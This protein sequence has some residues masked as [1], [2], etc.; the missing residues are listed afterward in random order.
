MSD[1]EAVVK[2][3]KGHQTDITVEGE[4]HHVFFPERESYDSSSWPGNC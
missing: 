3:D 1:M 2:G 4:N